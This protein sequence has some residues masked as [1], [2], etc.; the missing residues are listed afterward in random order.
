M[1]TFLNVAGGDWVSR[2]KKDMFHKKDKCMLT[3]VADP[4]YNAF[5]ARCNRRK[6]SVSSEIEDLIIKS[7]NEEDMYRKFLESYDH[8]RDEYSDT[9]NYFTDENDDSEEE[10]W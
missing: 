3:H 1:I 10:E 8:P 5:T 9:E 2:P 7:L 4:V 6:R